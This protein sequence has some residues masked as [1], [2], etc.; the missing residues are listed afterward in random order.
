MKTFT[1]ADSSHTGRVGE[2]LARNVIEIL[3]PNHW[4]KMEVRRRAAAREYYPSNRL[5]R[6]ILPQLSV[7]YSCSIFIYRPVCCF[8]SDTLCLGPSD[9]KLLKV[10][11]K[12]VLVGGQRS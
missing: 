5:D 2:P 1:R 6:L 10:S 9:D 12:I 3:F 4:F 8:P 7:C 11:G